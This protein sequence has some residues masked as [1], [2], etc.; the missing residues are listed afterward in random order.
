MCP[1]KMEFGKSQ[2]QLV[3]LNKQMSGE[4]KL[5]ISSTV[6]KLQYVYMQNVKYNNNV[7]W[8]GSK[9]ALLA[10]SDFWNNMYEFHAAFIKI[11]CGYPFLT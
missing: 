3:V 8:H 5:I 11:R 9:H 7:N 4:K 6:L 2:I 1:E 10:K